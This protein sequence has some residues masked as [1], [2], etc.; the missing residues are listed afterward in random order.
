MKLKQLLYIG[1][2][3]L[4]SAE[5][6]IGTKFGSVSS[7]NGLAEAINHAPVIH[8]NGSLFSKP[9]LEEYEICAEGIEYLTHKSSSGAKSLGDLAQKVVTSPIVHTAPTTKAIKLSTYEESLYKDVLREFAD[10]HPV[11]TVGNVGSFKKAHIDGSKSLFG[12]SYIEKRNGY[13][14]INYE[15]RDS[16]FELSDKDKLLRSYFDEKTKTYIPQA[17]SDKNLVK[18]VEEFLNGAPATKENLQAFLEYRDMKFLKENGIPDLNVEKLKLKSIAKGKEIAKQEEVYHN[19]RQ[20]MYEELWRPY[21]TETFYRVIGEDELR[22]VLKGKEIISK[23]SLAR[24]NRECVDVTTNPS[25]HDIFYGETKYRLTF[26]TKLSDGSYNEKFLSHMY[27]FR[28]EN[29]HYQVPSYSI[30]DV[31][32]VHAWNGYDWVKVS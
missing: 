1:K 16:I 21:H 2:R 13:G 15:C 17:Y 8:I 12:V 10:M 30:S 3:I 19:K 7:S 14:G 25:Y 11:E 24:Y 9:N 5:K 27:D 31:A 22:Q 18:E 29:R 26:K 6:R 23:N 32:E 20:R 4:S 28:P